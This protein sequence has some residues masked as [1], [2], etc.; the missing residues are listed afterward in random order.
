MLRLVTLAG[1][2]VPLPGGETRLTWTRRIEVGVSLGVEVRG[3]LVCLSTNGV[4]RRRIDDASYVPLASSVDAH[5]TR[6]ADPEA[7]VPSRARAAMRAFIASTMNSAISCP[8]TPRVGTK[9]STS[10]V[11]ERTMRQGSPLKAARS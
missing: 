5:H 7:H 4:H 1:R 9:A 11:A 3:W 6:A 8:Q 2:G 10:S